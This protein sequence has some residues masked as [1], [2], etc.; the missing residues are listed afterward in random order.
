MSN[1]NKQERDPA[2]EAP[3]TDDAIA[4]SQS[5]ITPEGKYSPGYETENP[6]TANVT[7]KKKEGE[8]AKETEQEEEKEEE[9]RTTSAMPMPTPQAKS[10]PQKSRATATETK[11]PLEAARQ[12]AQTSREREEEAERYEPHPELRYGQQRRYREEEERE[13]SSH[14]RNYPNEPWRQQHQF[15]RQYQQQ[16][17]QH[18]Y[19]PRYQQRYNQPYQPEYARQYQQQF[20]PEHEQRFYQP[21]SQLGYQQQQYRS[22]GLQESPRDYAQRYQQQRQQYPQAY[23]QQHEPRQRTQ[24]QPYRGPLGSRQEGPY[25]NYEEFEN[26]QNNGNYRGYGQPYG[27][28]FRAAEAPM[29]EPERERYFE[30][31]YRRQNAAYRYGNDVNFGFPGVN[32]QFNMPR[33]RGEY[34]RDYNR[35]RAEES[36]GR[37]SGDWTN[38]GQGFNEYDRGRFWEDDQDWGR[39]TESHRPERDSDRSYTPGRTS[40]QYFGD[41]YVPRY[42]SDWSRGFEDVYER[43]MNEDPWYNARRDNDNRYTWQDTDRFENRRAR[44][45][46]HSE[47]DEQRNQRYYD[48]RTPRYDED[49]E[50]SSSSGRTSPKGSRRH[51]QPQQQRSHRPKKVRRH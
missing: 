9:A 46:R 10:T 49:Y 13:T 24:Q 35:S 4:K 33:P 42:S 43:G 11:S 21:Q 50:Y 18:G 41:D 3:E 34:N 30:E 2:K 51:E 12:R 40:R 22:Y 37:G 36:F 7:G 17:M 27:Q 8:P 26:E 28:R 44:Q 39:R 25:T 16:N 48:E 31:R 23:S 5:A 29:S 47:D 14:W 1:K 19:E 20:V 32:E 38:Q 45:S 15:E 6:Q